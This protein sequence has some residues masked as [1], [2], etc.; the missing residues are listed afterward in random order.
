MKP[1]IR[2]EAWLSLA[3]F[4]L[5]ASYSAA[6]A[7]QRRP[8][9]SGTKLPSLLTAKP[10]KEDPKD[11]ELR[12]LLKARYND[13]V[14]EMKVLSKMYR[15]GRAGTDA[16]LNEAGQ[17]LVRAGLELYDKPAERV[18]LLT[19]YVELTMLVEKVVQGRYDTGQPVA[20]ELHRARYQRLD[21]EIRLLR[22][23]REG[24]QA[25]GK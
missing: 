2:P 4:L 15:E 13:A 21:A 14:G 8:D 17:R 20:R 16:L 18:A 23:K 5:P 3:L 1:A 9:P 24:G 22:A 7:P 10:V 11:D 19:Q 12:K 6:Q 25:K